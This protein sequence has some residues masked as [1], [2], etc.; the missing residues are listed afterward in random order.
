MRSPAH[1]TLQ[2][3]Y[4]EGVHGPTESLTY[5]RVHKSKAYSKATRA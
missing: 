4:F 1:L 5:Q 3:D 2:Y